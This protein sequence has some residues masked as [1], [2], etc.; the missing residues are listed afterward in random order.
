[1][2]YNDN[3][4]SAGVFNM[5]DTLDAQPQFSQPS[6]TK[7]Y[8]LASIFER[9]VAFIFDFLLF[10]SAYIWLI[11]ILVVIIGFYTTP[12]QDK[13]FMSAFWVSFIAY[14]AFF[15]CGGRQTLGKFLM[16][17]KIVKKGTDEPLPFIKALIRPFGYFLSVLTFFGGF[18]LA[19]ISKR[20]HALEDLLVG[21]EVI[22]IREKSAAEAVVTSMLGTLF[23]A[24]AVF[25][26]YYIFF[27]M[28]TDLQKAQVSAAQQQV[29]RIAFLQ[30]L[31]KQNFGSYTSDMVRLG[32][33]SG[34]PVKFQRDVQNNLRRRGFTMGIDKNGYSIKGI[35]KDK[36]DTEVRA[37]K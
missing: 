5:N 19:L 8:E 10:F 21:S 12:L 9:A 20:R 23:M 35:A 29:D 18:A 28:P 24:A 26:I 15:S 36:D 37:S 7:Q 13:M 4:Y 33:I 27:M 25:Y 14:H 3:R 17:I 6:E 11:Y 2:I 32:L 16:G 31:H 22:S 30:D 34:D 1:M